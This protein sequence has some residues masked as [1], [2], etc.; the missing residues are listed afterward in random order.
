MSR[1]PVWT[2]SDG[3]TAEWKISKGGLKTALHWL[4]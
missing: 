1:E 3:K 4:S 2:T